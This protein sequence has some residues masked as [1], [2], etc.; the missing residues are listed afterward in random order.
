MAKKKKSNLSKK[1]IANIKLQWIFLFLSIITLAAYVNTIGYGYTLDD[2][3]VITENAYTKKGLSGLKEIFSYDSFRGFFKKEGKENLVAGGRYR[4]LSQAMFA[5]EYA[6]FGLQPWV[7]HLVSVILYIFLVCSIFYIVFDLSKKVLKNKDKAILFGLL[8]ALFFSIHP[9]HTEVVANIKGRDE[10]LALLGSVWSLYFCV[11]YWEKKDIRNAIFAGSCL[12]LATLSKENAIAFLAII[13]VTIYFFYSRKLRD[14]VLA[15][16]PVFLGGLLYLTIRFAVLGFN[17]TD[18]LPRELM[19]NPFLKLVDGQYIP[20][21]INDKYPLIIYGL[22]KYIQLLVFPHPLSHDYY[23]RVFGELT[24]ASPQVMISLLIIGALFFLA[25]RSFY[26]QAL[27]SFSIIYFAITI[28]LTSNIL[29]PIGTHISERFL[30]TPSIA[31]CL[32][33]AA[34]IK[35]V[36][37]RRGRNSFL[38]ILAIVSISYMVKTITRNTVWESNYTLFKHDVR[39]SSGSAKVQNAVGGELIAQA[40]N[41]PDTM[42]R[43]EML[44]EAI[45]HLQKAVQ[46]HP[47]YKNA[48]LLLGNARFY[49]KDY[50]KAIEFYNRALLLDPAYPE[51]LYNRALA[52]RDYGR[53]AGEKLG[54]LA[55]AIEYLEKAS[56]QLQDDYETNRLLGIAYGNL[57]Q[58]AKAIPFFTKA[59]AL[60]TDDAWANYNLGLAYLAMQDSANANLYISRARSL[61]PEVGR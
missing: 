54:D 52:Q 31:F 23:P 4:P 28:F 41:E 5:V 59:L 24:W 43:R 36:Y 42:I 45:L 38:V 57:G 11:R 16:W 56:Q 13:P 30:F 53:Y 46:I 32:L 50:L 34:G 18:G 8:S 26:R 35:S 25:V 39:I 49:L 61:N 51:A 12:F 48:F 9:I 33:L 40:T 29:F 17:L 37:F 19:N 14:I 1:G 47:G 6:F 15:V 55:V 58:P 7:G 60:K 27:V 22:A 10:I 20:M 2:A 3:V 21:S 44:Q